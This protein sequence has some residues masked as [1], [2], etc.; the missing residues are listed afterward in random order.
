M[1]VCCGKVL[2]VKLYMYDMIKKFK[3]YLIVLVWILII[4]I[5]IYL[6]VLF[7][8]DCEKWIGLVIVLGY[9]LLK[10]NV[11]VLGVCRFLLVWSLIYG[12]GGGFIFVCMSLIILRGFLCRFFFRCKF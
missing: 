8:W 11:L 7:F 2:Y 9:F 12:W 6:V 1:F 3:W 10:E 4:V 5:D